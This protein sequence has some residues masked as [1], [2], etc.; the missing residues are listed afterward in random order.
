[1]VMM[2]SVMCGV[3][4]AKHISDKTSRLHSIELLL[5]EI[6]TQIKFC[7]KSLP[8]IFDMLQKQK[9]FDNLMFLRLLD[10]NGDS[11]SDSLKLSI[12]NDYY[13]TDNERKTILTLA[14]SL[15]S[16]DIQGQAAA[17]DMAIHSIS[18]QYIFEKEQSFQ[19]KRLY[20][21]MGV[22]IGAALAVL[23]I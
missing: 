23:M 4:A 10:L 19:K 8:Q 21:S 6:E 11:F 12:S 15:G 20:L 16:T 1:M 5:C 18:S 2:S 9:R 17:I 3:M 13:L 22:L 14:D 7:A